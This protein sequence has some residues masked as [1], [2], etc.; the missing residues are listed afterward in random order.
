MKK[1]LFC[2]SMICAS[3]VFSADIHNTNPVQDVKSAQSTSQDQEI[4]AFLMVL[5]NNE[6]AAAHLATKNSANKKVKGFA[7]LMIKDH[8]KNLDETNSLS[9]KDQLAPLESE[10][11]IAL[12]NK[13]T[14]E[15]AVLTPLTK[16]N[17]DKMYINDMVKGHADALIVI[18]NVLL[19][20]VSNKELKKHLLATRQHVIHHLNAAKKIQK[21]MS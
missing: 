1:A 10:Q 14:Q 6:L 12:K 17:F 4:V 20:K 19:K 9:T 18:D 2:F 7:E 3:A 13:G 11:V 5:N 15:I 21:Q 16:V 8:T